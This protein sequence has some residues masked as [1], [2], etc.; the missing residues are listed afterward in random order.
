MLFITQKKLCISPNLILLWVGDSK[1]T[2][3]TEKELNIAIFLF[4]IG[5]ITLSSLLSITFPNGIFFPL[6]LSL[7]SW[8]NK[9]VPNREKNIPVHWIINFSSFESLSQRVDY[10][11]ILFLRGFYVTLFS[12]TFRRG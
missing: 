8:E 9:N 4:G 7:S 6:H 11:F 1:K 12:L 10:R 3:N 5:L 2:T